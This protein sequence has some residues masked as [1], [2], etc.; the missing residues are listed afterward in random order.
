VALWL[1]E[2]GI[3]LLNARRTAT[4]SVDRRSGNL[5]RSVPPNETGTP[6]HPAARVGRL[7]FTGHM[8]STPLERLATLLSGGFLLGVFVYVELQV[9]PGILGGG[10]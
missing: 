4:S 1:A 10:A 9:W 7:R 6:A 2:H 3:V 5:A 8:P